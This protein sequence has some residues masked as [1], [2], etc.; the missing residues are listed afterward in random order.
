MLF[1]VAVWAGLGGEMGIG[2]RTVFHVISGLISVPVTLYAGLPF[3][4]SA[5][6]ALKAGRANMDVPISLA[7]LLS[8]VLSIYQTAI[9]ANYAYF[10]ASVTLLFFLLIGRYLDHGLRN[11]QWSSFYGHLSAIRCRP[12]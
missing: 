9:G 5:W 7:V 12:R 6:R 10:D 8:L 11:T 1:S 2:T 3:Y 4:R